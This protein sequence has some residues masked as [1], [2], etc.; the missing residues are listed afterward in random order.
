MKAFGQQIAARR[1]FRLAHVLVTAGAFVTVARTARAEELESGSTRGF[2][3]RQDSLQV[4]FAF[5]GENVA[6][7]GD[8]CPPDSTIPCILGSGGG[9]LVRIGYRASRSWFIGGAY[10]FTRHESA[11]LL[12]LPILQQGRAEGRYYFDRG[13]RTTGYLSAGAGVHLYGSDW[14]ASAWGGVAQVGAGVE[15]EL[16]PNT[17]VGCALVYRALI[18]KAWTDGAGE[19][20]SDAVLGF[21]LAHL[22]GLEFALEV[23]DPVPHL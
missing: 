4:G 9:M 6:S 11:N 1:R 2:A 10:E 15:F 20:R 19:R 13:E 21:G 16:S 3:P 23:R 22:I 8:V 7:A 5:V 14:A 18:E 12:R 17:V